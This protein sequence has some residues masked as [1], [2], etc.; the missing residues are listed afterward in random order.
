MFFLGIVI[1][2]VGY[3]ILP[4]RIQTSL[5]NMI[6]FW[7]EKV[8]ERID[9]SGSSLLLRQQQINSMQKILSNKKNFVNI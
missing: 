2:I 1:M 3:T 5:S 8:A 7:D 6:M 4:K 9:M